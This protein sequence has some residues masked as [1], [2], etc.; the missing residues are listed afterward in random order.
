M[1]KVIM[2]LAENRNCPLHIQ[3]NNIPVEFQN[4]APTCNT[5]LQSFVYSCTDRATTHS[6]R[7]PVIDQGPVIDQ[8]VVIGY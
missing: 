2:I 3:A 7:R 4:L 8:L 6:V 5:L 1:S